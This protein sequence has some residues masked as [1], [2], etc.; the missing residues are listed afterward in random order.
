[1]LDSGAVGQIFK[2]TPDPFVGFNGPA[3]ALT[4]NIDTLVAQINATNSVHT[5]SAMS[6]MTPPDPTN[7]SK[8]RDRGGKVLVYHGVSD[9]IFSA[10]D[11]EAWYKGVQN[12]NNGDASAFARFFRI[13][14]M[15]HCSG[16]PTA[17]QFDPLDAM[18]KWVETGLAP[19]S[20]IATARGA[21]NAGGANAELPATWAATRTRPLCSYPRVARYSGS[22]SVEMA[23]SFACLP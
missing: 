3:F 18:V 7:L 17:D 14:G 19:D 16:G 2:V 13:P 6:S 1:M 8:L 4:S 21:G 15:G 22:G 10:N 12:N 23:A 9:Q 5:E 11:S 20:L